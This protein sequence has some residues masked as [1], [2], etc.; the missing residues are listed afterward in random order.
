MVFWQP[1][2]NIN[3]G[4]WITSTDANGVA[5]ITLASQTAGILR[6]TAYLNDKNQKRAPDVTIDPA[7]VDQQ[8]SRFH[9]DKTEIGS[10]GNDAALLNVMLRDAYGNAI[11]GKTVVL[12]GA[13]SLSGFAVTPVRDN[14]D[15]SYQAR[16]TSMEKGRVSLTASLEGKTIG[17][18]VVISVGAT[19]PDL[20]FDNAL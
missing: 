16:A 7:P 17:S 10:D 11:S 3:A 6:M 4:E 18:A 8:V 1:E 12:Q 2:G 9:A 19:T 15:G 13:E 14:H 20:R 5:H